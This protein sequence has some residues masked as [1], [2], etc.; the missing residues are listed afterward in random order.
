M[1]L[2]ESAPVNCYM[3]RHG[4]IE[5]QNCTMIHDPVD[6]SFLWL[7]VPQVL[8]GLAQVL[9]NMTVLE[10]ICA[11]APRTMQGLLI[12]LW[13]AMFSIRYLPMGL[14]DITFQTSQY[15]YIYQGVRALIVLVSLVLF[16]FVAQRYKYRVREDV[17]PEQ[18]LIE[19]VTE[20]RME[21]EK[22]YWARREQ[23]Q[24]YWDMMEQRQPLL[25]SKHISK[26]HY[27]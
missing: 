22:K 8:H 13:Y 1:K 17:V 19:D 20:R 21:Q 7:M 3:L 12:G 6:N 14:L 25:D 15:F 26:N 27:M 5:E 10:F 2:A 4:Y 11:Q 9:T 16:S 18:W 24:T 23:E